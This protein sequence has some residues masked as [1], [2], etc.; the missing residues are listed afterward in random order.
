M[1]QIKL[2]TEHDKKSP[3]SEAY[4]T[5]RTNLRFAGADKP[6]KFIGVT[7]S[8]PSEGKSTTISN[9]AVVMAMDG[10][11]VLLI[12]CDMRKPM[13][14]RIFELPNRGVTNCI[15]TGVSVESVIRK[16]VSPNLDILTSGPVP[17]NPSE[18]IGS[19][20]MT[21]LLKQAGE[22]YDY[23]LIDLPPV[24]PVT[25]AAVMSA[26]IDGMIL[27]IGSGDVTP[28]EG[29]RTKEQLEQAGAHMIGVILNK[30]P[31]QHNRGYNYY[32]YH[33]G[34]D[35]G[36]EHEHYGRHKNEKNSK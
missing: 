29:K 21:S 25:D 2:I 6:L 36:E 28:E 26:K 23:V 7:S 4:R 3:V 31:V 22:S 18:M 34:V 15:A 8:I 35:D 32:Y 19:E 13:I 14:H 24:L 30:V 10:K 33:Y 20:K 11:K 5:I 16:E 27:V 12:D 17:P 9:L 1:A